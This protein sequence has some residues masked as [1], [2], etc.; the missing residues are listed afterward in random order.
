MRLML[1]AVALAIIPAFA[2]ISPCNAAEPAS[3]DKPVV[4]ATAPASTTSP[5]PA[6]QGE[7]AGG[8]ATQKAG[9]P[10]ATDHAEVLLMGPIGRN[11]VV[12]DLI[13]S[14][15]V[16]SGVYVE[17][18]D[19]GRPPDQLPAYLSGYKIVVMQ[20]ES[21]L[22]KDKAARKQL[23]DYLHNG[24]SI[25][26]CKRP[27]EIKWSDNDPQFYV[28]CY[29]VT[30][31]HGVRTQN[32]AFLKRNADRPDRD[33]ILTCANFMVS[34]SDLAKWYAIGND[35]AYMHFEGLLKTAATYHQ[36]NL[37]QFVLDQLGGLAAGDGLKKL[38]V[39]AGH[40]INEFT[41]PGFERYYKATLD[42]IGDVDKVRADAQTFVM[43]SEISTE[44]VE[45][46]GNIAA[47]GKLVN[48]PAYFAP[49]IEMMRYAHQTLYDPQKQLWAHGWQSGV[50]RAPAWGRGQGWMLLGLVGAI[51]SLPKD[52]PD[53]P[54]L[55]KYLEE[56]AE[57]LRRYQDPETGLWHNIIDE[58]SSRLEASGTA[59]IVRSYC[60]AWLAGVCRTPEVKEMLTKAWRG[61][62]AHTIGPKTYSFV[63]EMGATANT[64]LYQT[65]P[66][67]GTPYCVTLAGPDYVQTFGPLVP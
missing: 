41:Q 22:L 59:M 23:Q 35:V 14:Y 61:L 34:D 17:V 45:P 40:L 58:P 64:G 11:D 29:E 9:E 3:A 49:V 63:W 5:A 36:D 16:E 12:Y 62:K 65:K 44:G 18:D 27:A 42:Q 24:G 8:P 55:V 20:R 6:S 13:F 46:L 7:P 66:A 1:C 2:V 39:F 47:K 38:A 26:F 54:V 48:D 30:K 28:I 60:H 4:S 15:L 67:S 19:R 56:E 31:K 51:E 25:V 50:P 21:P 33:V 57:G 32:P 37:R 53:Y 52:H 43:G 10:A